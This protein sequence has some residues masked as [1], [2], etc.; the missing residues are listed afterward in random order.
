MAPHNIFYK[1]TIKKNIDELTN[2]GL[3]YDEIEMFLEN[4]GNAME[5]LKTKYPNPNPD[6]L[7]V[8][9][10]N[11]KDC[12]VTNG[13]KNGVE[14]FITEKCFEKK[15][16]FMKNILDNKKFVDMNNNS[17]PFMLPPFYSINLTFQ[18]DKNRNIPADE[19]FYNILNIDGII[20]MTRYLN[21]KDKSKKKRD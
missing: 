8:L 5:K 13:I 4:P 21:L 3:K 11:F 15:D 14:F 1:N 6:F 16:L 17:L 18:I 2:I 7:N 19:A 10:K 9:S 20:S 12:I